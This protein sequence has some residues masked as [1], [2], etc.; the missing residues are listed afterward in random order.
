MAVR[1]IGQR[2]LYTEPTTS[3]PRWQL[4]NRGRTDKK[5]P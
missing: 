1:L 4:G 2:E 3:R 5:V